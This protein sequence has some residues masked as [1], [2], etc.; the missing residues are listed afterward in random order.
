MEVEGGRSFE[1]VTEQGRQAGTGNEVDFGVHQRERA[2][3]VLALSWAVVC[4]LW[5]EV[6]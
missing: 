6:E 5:C 4:V 3:D 1:V 2:G